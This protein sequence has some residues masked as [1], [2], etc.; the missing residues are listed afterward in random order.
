MVVLHSLCLLTEAMFTTDYMVCGVAPYGDN[1]VVLSYD[2]QDSQQEV[3]GLE[4]TDYL[5][6]T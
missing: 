2:E 5:N 4:H 3:R 1:L 6:L